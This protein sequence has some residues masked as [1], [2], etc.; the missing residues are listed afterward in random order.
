M[1][2]IGGTKIIL[3]KR[4]K[5]M[6]VAVGVHDRDRDKQ[7]LKNHGYTGIIG[8]KKS[9]TVDGKRSTNIY[10]IWGIPPRK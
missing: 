1:S 8:V 3:G 9:G 4:R 2:V 7:I 5:K 10:E 6:A